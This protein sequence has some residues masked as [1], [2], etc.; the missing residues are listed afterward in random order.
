MTKKQLSENENYPEIPD[1]SKITTVITVG[2]NQ[3]PL[4]SKSC[5]SIKT[6]KRQEAVKSFARGNHK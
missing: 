1:M 2:K 3:Q 5:F 4:S 6:P